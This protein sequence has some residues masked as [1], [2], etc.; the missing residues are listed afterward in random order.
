MPTPHELR[1]MLS[2]YEEYDRFTMLVGDLKD[3]VERVIELE[4][5]LRLRNNTTLETIARMEES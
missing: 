4:A 1:E 3:L 5:I 2:H